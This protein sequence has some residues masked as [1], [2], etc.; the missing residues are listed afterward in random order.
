[1]TIFERIEIAKKEFN[2][3]NE[4]LGE[5]VGVSE[6]A[7]GQIMRR[8]S[9]DKLKEKALCDYLDSLENKPEQ[10]NPEQSQD[11]I[12]K[13][14]NLFLLKEIEFYK[15]TITELVKSINNNK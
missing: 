6:M 15:N 3:N 11:S 1:M 12:L 13:E 7:F 2:L 5:V 8:K 9:M 4:K 10:K 14:Q